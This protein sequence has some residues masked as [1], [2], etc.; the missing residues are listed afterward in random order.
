[1]QCDGNEW[2]VFKSQLLTQPIFRSGRRG[3]SA[4]DFGVNQLVNFQNNS[5]SSPIT[6]QLPDP[7]TCQGQTVHLFNQS[8]QNVQMNQVGASAFIGKVSGNA[9]TITMSPNSMYLLISNYNT[10]I[11]F[12]NGG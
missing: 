3:Y 10:W 5:D 2:A 8:S 11:I 12:I 6:F 1:M 9:Y 4:L 7:T